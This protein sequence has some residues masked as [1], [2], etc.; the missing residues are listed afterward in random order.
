M[1][2]ITCTIIILCTGGALG[3]AVATY[4]TWG[5]FKSVGEV[6]T[7]MDKKQ[8]QNLYDTAMMILKKASIE[9]IVT[10]NAMV[11]GDF[12]LKKQLLDSVV[13]H[14]KNRLDMELC[15]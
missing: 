15:E 4:A 8:K 3:G 1:Q 12:I 14:V 2:L 10:L 6:I 7:S 11:A 13:D 5:K 9:D